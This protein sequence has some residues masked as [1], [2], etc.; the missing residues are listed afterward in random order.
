MAFGTNLVDKVERVKAWEKIAGHI[1]LRVDLDVLES[2][3]KA[4]ADDYLKTLN[5][6]QVISNKWIKDGFGCPSCKNGGK[7][8]I[9]ELIDQ[10]DHFK[11]FKE[12]EGYQTVLN[13]LLQQGKN[14]AI[15]SHWVMKFVKKKNL[16]PTKFEDFIDE[17]TGDFSADIIVNGKFIECKSWGGKAPGMSNVPNQLINYFNTQNS[18]SK[19]EFQ[20]D[21]DRWI[22]TPE[23]L[24]QALKSK[25]DLFNTTDEVVWAKYVSMVESNVDDI[26]IGNVDALIDQITS[27]SIF[28]KIINP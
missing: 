17:A 6:D 9:N 25:S 20:F 11:Q 2:L 15:G 16:S 3:S 24:N 4:L 10:L 1:Q 26:P 22:P 19:F 7:P 12:I 18:L 8:W 5:L 21:P 27:S 23:D 14:Q 28:S 13:Q